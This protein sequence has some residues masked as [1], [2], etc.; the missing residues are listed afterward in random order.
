M[1]SESPLLSRTR[2]FAIAIAKLIE[3]VP[4]TI[5][6]RVIANQLMRSATST[7]ANYRAARRARS[8][9][10]FVAKIGVVLEEIDESELWLDFLA[11]LGF[12]KEPEIKQLRRE[13]NELAAMSFAARKTVLRKTTNA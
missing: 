1:R 2:A 6:G 12:C 3:L 9:A 5:Q 8:D 4:D 13:A 10:E 7:A 11:E